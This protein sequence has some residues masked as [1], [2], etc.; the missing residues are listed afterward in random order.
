[1]RIIAVE[2]YQYGAYNFIVSIDGQEM[3]LLTDQQAS[4]L[5]RNAE[6]RLR[7]DWNVIKALRARRKVATD[8]AEQLEAYAKLL[9]TETGVVELLDAAEAAAQN[10]GA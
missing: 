5:K 3:D 4:H 2:S 1:M 6:V 9:R 10:G 8:V 7:S